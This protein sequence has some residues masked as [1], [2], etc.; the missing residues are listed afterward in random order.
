MMIK[1]RW[2]KTIQFRQ[3]VLEIPI[4]AIP[5][6]ILCPVKAV[7]RLLQVNKSKP[8]GPLLALSDDLVFTYGMLQKKLKQVIADLG[9]NKNKYSTHSLRRGA[10]VWAECNGV[11]HSMIKV[12][13][14][15][16]S[17]AFHRYLQFPEEV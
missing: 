5:N 14:D 9:L 13:G 16:S 12:Y 3:C 8:H 11:E 10:V 15:W 4:Y 1:I 2:S 6:S 7:K 17:D